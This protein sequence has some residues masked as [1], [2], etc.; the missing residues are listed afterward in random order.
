MIILYSVGVKAPFRGTRRTGSAPAHSRRAGEPAVVPQ[1]PRQV[2][3]DRQ[4]R[5]P[6]ADLVAG[7]QVVAEQGQ[8]EGAVGGRA[9]PAVRPGSSAVPSRRSPWSPSRPASSSGRPGPRSRTSP[10]MF[11]PRSRD[12]RSECAGSRCPSPAHSRRAR[13]RRSPAGLLRRARR[14]RH[15]KQVNACVIRNESARLPQMM[16]PMDADTVSA[17]R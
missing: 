5:Q 3:V 14:K 15:G 6:D 2:A 8:V 7:H 9:G 1:G 17:D 12:G 16:P 4:Q 13:A 11:H 10:S